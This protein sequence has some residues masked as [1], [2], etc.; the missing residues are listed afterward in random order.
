MKKNLKFKV[1]IV[2]ATSILLS[3]IVLTHGNAAVKAGS[4][5]SKAGQKTTISSVKYVCTKMGKK[6]T[7]QA[8]KVTSTSAV[9][10]I[11]PGQWLVGKEVKPG[12]YRTTAA[13]CYY[14]RLSGFTGSFNEIISN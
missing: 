2:S 14:Q 13:T 5:C 1:A 6:L 11:K 12:I 10:D 4:T 9:A 7:W 3:L 8:E